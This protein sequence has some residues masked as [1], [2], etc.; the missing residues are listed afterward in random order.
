M[1]WEKLSWI[2]R[3]RLRRRVLE[4]LDKPKT[5]TILSKELKTHRSTI[6]EILKQM[7]IPIPNHP[8][9]ERQLWDK[10]NA[11]HYYYTPPWENKSIDEAET[12]PPK[13]LRATFKQF[14]ITLL[15]K[16]NALLES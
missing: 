3:G 10:L 7:N 1:E 16:V 15:K 9:K 4:V 13:G 5:A 14:L 12:K 2:I 8:I 11:W 6:S